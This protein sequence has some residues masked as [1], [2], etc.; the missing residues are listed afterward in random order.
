MYTS[1]GS[2]RGWLVGLTRGTLTRSPGPP[3]GCEERVA[4]RA[5]SLPEVMSVVRVLLRKKKGRT[6]CI[7][8]P[9]PFVTVC[10]AHQSNTHS[11]DQRNTQLTTCSRLRCAEPAH[12]PPQRPQSLPVRAPHTLL[13]CTRAHT[14]SNSM[15]HKRPPLPPGRV[16]LERRLPNARRSTLVGNRQAQRVAHVRVD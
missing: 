9:P 15:P 6:L 4:L 1:A 7:T 16:R 10:R 2:Y 8:L 3:I 13:L 14:R 5:T 11:H 12:E